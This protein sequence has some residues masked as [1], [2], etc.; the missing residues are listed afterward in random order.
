MGEKGGEERWAG[1]RE[2]ELSQRDEATLRTEMERG[3]SEGNRDDRVAHSRCWRVTDNMTIESERERE[4]GTT[5][6]NRRLSLTPLS[7]ADGL[8]LQQL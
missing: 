7:D 4:D 6:N 2:R 5:I 3:C 8:Q 1:E